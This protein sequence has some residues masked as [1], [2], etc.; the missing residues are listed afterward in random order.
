MNNI[1]KLLEAVKFYADETNWVREENIFSA[2]AQESI[3][4]KDGGEL[5]R[6]VLKEITV[7]EESD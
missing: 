1:D 7:E 5:A 6:Q 2:A 3:I 4:M